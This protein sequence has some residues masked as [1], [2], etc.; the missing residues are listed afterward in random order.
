MDKTHNEYPYYFKCYHRQLHVHHGNDM[1]VPWS[2]AVAYA[3]L[4]Q[5]R[6]SLNPIQG[7]IFSVK[8]VQC[9][10]L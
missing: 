9:M 3:Y 10:N 6:N 7:G 2:R 8:N 1:L 4:L 5:A